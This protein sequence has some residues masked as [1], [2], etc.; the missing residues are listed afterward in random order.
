MVQRK[1]GIYMFVNNHQLL[2]TKTLFAWLEICS[3]CNAKLY[4][5]MVVHRAT[6]LPS[7][8]QA[9]MTGYTGKNFSTLNGCAIK[10]LLFASRTGHLAGHLGWYSPSVM[11][12]SSL[13]CLSS[14]VQLQDSSAVSL[15][16]LWRF[17]SILVTCKTKVEIFKPR[18][19]VRQKRRVWGIITELIRSK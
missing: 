7:Y 13:F 11:L 14:Y 12:S 5:R 9:R 4:F 16:N 6:R 15:K 10:I 1:K 17:N 8:A 3:L 19:S 2:K 18:H